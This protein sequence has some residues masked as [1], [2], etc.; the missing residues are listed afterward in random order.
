[1]TGEDFFES[2]YDLTD[3]ADTAAHYAKFAAQ[4]ETA[5]R[6]NGYCTPARCAEALRAAQ[7]PL[8]TAVLDIGCG[9]GLSGEALYEAGYETLDGTD[10]SAQMLS[11]ARGKGLYR[12]LWQGDL[13]ALPD[14]IR[15][16]AVVAAGV[17]NPAHAPASVL[18][19]VLARLNPDGVFVFSLNDHAIAD[20]SY[21]GR[22]HEVLDAG[23]ATLL[24][25]EYGP[26]MPGQDLQAW[27]LALQRR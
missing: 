19:E 12:D 3:P 21:E 17:L 11:V 7:V 22:V 13:T 10:F 23:G 26:H 15:Y 5:M 9:T 6:E 2:I 25:R 18:D 4:Y 8:K 24:S 16:D 27:V 1:M 20:G 14:D